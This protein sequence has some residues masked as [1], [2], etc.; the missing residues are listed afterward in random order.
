MDSHED[1]DHLPKRQRRKLKKEQQ[2][3]GRKRLVWLVVIAGLGMVGYY[4]RINREVLPPTS[5]AGHVEKSPESHILDK[6]MS[7]EIQKHMLEHADG[8]G[9]PG[10]V[11]NYNCVDFDCRSDEV[12]DRLKAIV[13]DYPEYVY[14]APYPGM[15]AKIAVSK[16]GQIITLDTVDEEAIRRFVE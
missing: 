13:L 5:M 2:R 14:L 16:I 10:V 11:I 7:V 8:E 15:T 6:P 4:W 3:R 1:W 9:R 12:I